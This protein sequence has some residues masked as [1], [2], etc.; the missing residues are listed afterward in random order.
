[1]AFRRGTRCPVAFISWA[2]V[3]E[4][5]FYLPATTL[6][7]LY[8]SRQLS[9]VEVTRAVL[10]RI[11]DTN[12]AVNAFCVLDEELA[13]TQAHASE[14]RWAK[15]RP[16]GVVDGVPVT[17]KDLILAR[18]WPTRRGSLT[19][20]PDQ[21]WNEDG[22]PVARLREQGAIIANAQVGPPGGALEKTVN[23]VK[24][25][26]RPRITASA[27]LAQCKVR[28]APLSLPA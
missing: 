11:A 28:P 8:R 16:M 3:T 25:T 13:L 20:D 26:H 22:P 2:A 24:F 21:S 4:D 17:V 18:G 5:I 19:I 14:Q 9:P 10:A 15:G 27:A 12:D 1:M 7:Q 23:Q 6:L